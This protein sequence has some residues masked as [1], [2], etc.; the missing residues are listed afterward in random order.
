MLAHVRPAF[1]A[2]PWFARDGSIEKDQSDLARRRLTRLA[3]RAAAGV[4]IQT[5]IVTGQPAHEIAALATR[6]RAG[7]IVMPIHAGSVLGR[8]AG[9]MIHHVLQ[10]SA[11]PVLALPAARRRRAR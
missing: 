7:L 8:P 5:R 1:Q 9:A 11:T 3:A 10:H 6:E 2:P 4:R